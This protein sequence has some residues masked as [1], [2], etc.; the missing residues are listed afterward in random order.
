MGA[1]EHCAGL[2][3]AS[4]RFLPGSQKNL[5]SSACFFLAD[6]PGENR[7]TVIEAAA[8]PGL[9]HA[10]EPRT[11]GPEILLFCLVTSSETTG[12]REAGWGPPETTLHSLCRWVWRTCLA[13]IFQVGFCRPQEAQIK[14]L[15]P[16][17]QLSKWICRR[18]ET[19]H[20]GKG[21]SFSIP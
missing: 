17:K 2:D 15:G 6:S 14:H 19:Q 9:P 11:D 1:W 13:V 16:G 10:H 8:T 12:S 20:S 7:G 5:V 21:V 4:T 18:P 3:W